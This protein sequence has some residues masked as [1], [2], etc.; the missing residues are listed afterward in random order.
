MYSK[1]CKFNS[2]ALV[3]EGQF[4]EMVSTAQRKYHHQLSIVWILPNAVLKNT[5]EELGKV[6]QRK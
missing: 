2:Y 1:I 3:N 4:D 6:G 5:A